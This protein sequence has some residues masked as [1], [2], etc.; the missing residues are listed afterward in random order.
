[1]VPETFL[2]RRPDGNGGFKF[3]FDTEQE[4][5]TPLEMDP[6]SAKESGIT[7][8][9][10]DI[11]TT[12][13]RDTALELMDR[14]IT[15]AGYSPQSFGLKIEGRADSGTALNIRE[16]KSFI[17]R[18]KKQAY[19]KN[20]IEDMLLIMQQIDNEHLGQRYTPFRPN[21]EMQDSLTNDL[22]QTA[23]AVEL[24]NRAEAASIETK[25]RLL[26]PDWETDQVKT[27]VAAITKER[28]IAPDPA[29]SLG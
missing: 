9:Q 29:E 14:I 28:G 16:R 11:R 13:H 1:M 7:L 10:F 21:V 24:I 22:V 4:I 26:H 6:M 18:A 20:A 19:W 8:A 23:T 27:E 5:F 25:V 17:T 15:N 2:E 12:E 3:T